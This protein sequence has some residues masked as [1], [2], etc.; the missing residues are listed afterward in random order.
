MT[1]V[2]SDGETLYPLEVVLQGTPVTLQSRN[3]PRREAW[4]NQV[5]E[6]TRYR[7]LETYELGLLDDRA[8]A[9]TIY[10]FPSAP[11]DGDIDNIVKLILDGM[12]GIAYLDDRAVERVSVQ[13]F[14]PD[15]GWEFETP[16]DRL[17]L[18]LDTAAPVVYLRVDD[19][20]SW[21][22]V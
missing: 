12:R 10:Y 7:Q 18:A 22:R 19:D 3:A 2:M 20:L 17:A 5:M 15:A 16:T 1:T 14:E 8:V 13:K 11:M 9:V 4:K 6:A 21:R